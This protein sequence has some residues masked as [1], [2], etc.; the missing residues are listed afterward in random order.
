MKSEEALLSWDITRLSEM[1]RRKEISPVDVVEQTLQRIE[2]RNPSLNAFVTILSEEAVREAKLAEAEI[3]AGDWKGPLHG[4]PIGLKDLIYTKGIRTTMGSEIFNDF[5]PQTDASVVTRIKQAGG[6]IVGKL[7]THQFAYGPTGDR[8]FFGPVHNPYDHSKITGGSSSGSGAA[9]AAG[10]CFA[11]LG[12]DTGGSIRIPSSICG[13]VGM[14]ATYGLVD[15]SDVFPLSQTL[16]HVGPMTRSVLDNALLLGVLSGGAFT[17]SMSVMEQGVEGMIIGIPSTYY[18]EMLDAEV[19]QKAEDAIAFFERNGAVIRPVEL[20]DMSLILQAQG[21]IIRSEAYAIHTELLRE[22][23]DT[24]DPEVKERL[25]EGVSIPAHEY[26]HALQ[27]RAEL[28][29]AMEQTLQSVDLLLTPTLPI[30]PVN[31]DERTVSLAGNSYH[32]RALLTRLTSPTNLTGHPSLTIPAGLSAAGLPIGIQ[33]IG[34]QYSE[35]ALYR[36]ARVFELGMDRCDA[37]G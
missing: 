21:I 5:L 6:I 31:I 35:S 2:E 17:A 7:N 27:K 8:S 9:V 24:Y 10:M 12:S 37:D 13:I 32:V 18:Y 16:D 11:A 4:V 22:H 30:L 36:A 28:Q 19:R 20:P 34:R 26:I 14:K 23:G 3:M 1:I 15:K 33:L 25:L 29:Q